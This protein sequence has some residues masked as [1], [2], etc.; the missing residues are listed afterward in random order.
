MHVSSRSNY[1]YLLLFQELLESELE[2]VLSMSQTQI[3]KV[4]AELSNVDDRSVFSH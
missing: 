2:A 3:R 4:L 1:M